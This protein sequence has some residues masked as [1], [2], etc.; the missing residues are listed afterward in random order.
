MYSGSLNFTRVLMSLSKLKV[1]SSQG[2]GSA[3]SLKVSPLIQTLNCGHCQTVL[4]LGREMC[5]VSLLR[6]E[7]DTLY[8]ETQQ[9][10]R[11]L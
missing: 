5:T 4:L 6:R 1:E 10:L 9:G 3:N 7:I 2:K 8:D 11:D